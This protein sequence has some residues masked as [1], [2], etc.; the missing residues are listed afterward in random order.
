MNKSV[1]EFD[2]ETKEYIQNM[3]N[4]QYNLLIIKTWTNLLDT[5]IMEHDKKRFR[6]IEQGF[7][8]I[9]DNATDEQYLSTNLM[10]LNLITYERLFRGCG[11]SSKKS[12]LELERNSGKDYV[13]DL[14]FSTENEGFEIR[15]VTDDE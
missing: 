5:A 10:T 6:D 2:K 1:K 13:R 8:F 15:F 11:N 14:D 9:L 3:T 12:E 7:Y 4:E